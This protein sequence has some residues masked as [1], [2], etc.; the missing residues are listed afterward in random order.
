[1]ASD[2]QADLQ[3]LLIVGCSNAG[4]TT[5]ARAL[6]LPLGRDVMHLDDLHPRSCRGAAHP[7]CVEPVR[8]LAAGER[9]LIEGCCSAGLPDL[10][11]R[12]TQIVWLDTSPLLCF[13]RALRRWPGQ[14]LE[15][16]TASNRSAGVWIEWARSLDTLPPLALIGRGLNR[17][18]VLAAILFFRLR[19]A[20]DIASAVRLT[21]RHRVVRL[22]SS[23]QAELWLQQ[24]TGWARPSNAEPSAESA[25]PT[26]A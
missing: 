20:R 9:W 5:L 12:A 4:K 18:R 23:A 17:L 2:I 8:E 7:S 21:A 6:A 22:R 16:R 1:L 3:R 14:T 13:G 26:G 11:R 25:S 24:T 10:A 19:D 15:R